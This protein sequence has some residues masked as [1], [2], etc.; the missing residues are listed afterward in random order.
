MNI[1]KIIRDTRNG[2]TIESGRTYKQYD[3]L[4]GKALNGACSS[5]IVFIMECYPNEGYS[6]L[7]NYVFGANDV[8]AVIDAACDVIDDYETG[9]REPLQKDSIL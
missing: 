3:L 9:K 5:D 6:R 2:I 7:V 8:D 4:E 1:F